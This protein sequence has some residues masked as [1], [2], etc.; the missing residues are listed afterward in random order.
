ML[1]RR[2]DLL[3]LLLVLINSPLKSQQTRIELENE[4]QK[5]LIKISEA[6]KI[7]KETEKSKNVTTGKLNVINK[8]INNRLS[9][10]SNLK[11]EMKFQNNEILDLSGVIYSLTNDLKI[12][13]N[14]YSE[15]IYY[16]YKSRSS[17]DKLGYVFS[18]NSYNQMFR[19]LG[20]IVQYTNSRKKQIQEIEIVTN[21]LDNQKNNLIHEKRIQNKLLS[22][23]VTENNKLQKLKRNQKKTISD[24]GKKER[25]IKK[26]IKE[27]RISLEQLD[28]LIK[29]VIRSERE[30]LSGVDLDL[31]KLTES[32]EINIGKLIWPV[33]SGFI[34]NKFGVHPH[35]VI[36]NVKV[37]N[38]GIDI[39]T[40][41][42]SKVYSVFSGKVSTVAF[43]P[44]M[45][46]VII[47][48]HGEYYTL[49][50][51]LKN[52]LVEKGDIITIGQNIAYIV[53]NSDGVSELQ[54][55]V[56]KNNIKLNPEKWIMNK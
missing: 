51:K 12:L 41:K 52:L 38:D 28:N 4:R 56:W 49:Y 2:F 27:R 32:F 21:E 24:L 15:M 30:K 25:R 55:Q 26:E 42:G 16:S 44:G 40:S 13:K 19:R 31:I 10:I 37:K 54:F 18:S 5:N 9:L 43:I 14:E 8:Q 45:N 50:A 34:S 46:N 11:K 33:S 47:I 6:E 17:L 29:E 20:Y 23:E 36:K 53:T 39:Q 7:L 35:P 1:L 22:D 48:N 3:V